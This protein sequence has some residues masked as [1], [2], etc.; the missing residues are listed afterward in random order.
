MLVFA[1]FVAALRP[2]VGADRTAAP[3]PPVMV[4]VG[5]ILL[6]LAIDMPRRIRVRGV[7]TWRHGDGSVVQN[8]TGGIWIDVALARQA[9][10]CRIEPA[11]LEQIEEGDAVEIVDGQQGQLLVL[12]D[13][14]RCV[15]H[16]SPRGSD[17]RHGRQKRD[18]GAGHQ[19]RHL[20][21]GRAVGLP[22]QARERGTHR[23]REDDH[24]CRQGSVAGI[25]VV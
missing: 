15:E 16:A 8:E 22:E 14:G 12:E 17:D 20:G 4:A 19:R 23:Q 9:G 1:V 11:A 24:R 18:L 6:Q 25:Q 10:I 7:V 2:A 13:R 3:E 21:D 5:E